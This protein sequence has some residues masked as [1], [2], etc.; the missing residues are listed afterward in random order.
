LRNN[1]VVTSFPVQLLVVSIVYAFQF[2]ARQ[3]VRTTSWVCILY[4]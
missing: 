2:N 4:V 1:N 3:D